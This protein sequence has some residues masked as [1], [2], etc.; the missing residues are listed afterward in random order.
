MARVTFRKYTSLPVLL[1]ILYSS[2]LTLSDPSKWEDKN[3]SYYIDTYKRLNNYKT[4]LVT[5]FSETIETYHHWKIYAGTPSGICIEFHKAK[6]IPM[7]RKQNVIMDYVK[8]A[9]I[10]LKVLKTEMTL[11]KFPF[12]KRIPF[13]DESEFRVLYYSCDKELLTYD[14][15]IDFKCIKAIIINPWLDKSISG[16]LINVINSF[17]GKHQFRVYQ[18]TLLENEK[19]KLRAQ[20]YEKMIKYA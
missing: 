4:V 13:S 9:R 7:M 6:L 15:E 1:N 14:I 10:N 11:E 2:K 3:D 20:Q 16:N 17:K 12:Y 18:S 19:W 5:C 8:Y